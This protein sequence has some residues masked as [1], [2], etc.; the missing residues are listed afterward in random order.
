MDAPLLFIMAALRDDVFLP[1][2]SAKLMLTDGNRALNSSCQLEGDKDLMPP[3]PPPPSTPDMAAAANFC[4]SMSFS[5]LHVSG[6]NSSGPLPLA[7]GPYAT[8]DAEASLCCSLM[9]L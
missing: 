4:C 1:Q 3:S 7:V 8:Y 9:G 6:L 5:L 2:L